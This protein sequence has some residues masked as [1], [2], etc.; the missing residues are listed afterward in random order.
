MAELTTLARPYAKAAF[1]AA[2]NAKALTEWS[3]A[4]TLAANVTGQDKVKSLLSSPNLTAEQKSASLVELCGDTLNDA[5]QNFISVLAENGRLSLLPQVQQLFELYKAN[6]EKAVDV[7]IQSAFEMT[8]EIEEKL[9]KTLT[10]KL[11][12]KVTLQTSVDKSLLGG[13]IIRA[14][15][16]VIDG[17]VRGKLAKLAE[18]MQG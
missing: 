9:A 15:D 11:D 4:L 1:E 8:S 10:A 2:R 18:A 14:G 7:D 6:Q 12:R 3:E 5:Q 16:T 17:S 13:A